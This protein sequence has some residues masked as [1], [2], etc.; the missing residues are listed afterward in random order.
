MS[1]LPACW[2]SV[3]LGQHRFGASRPGAAPRVQ[4]VVAGVAVSVLEAF[5][6]GRTR[7]GDG[8]PA[9]GLSHGGSRECPDG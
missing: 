9:S 7:S 6:G 2:Q 5:G 4:G 8:A 1:A 3:S